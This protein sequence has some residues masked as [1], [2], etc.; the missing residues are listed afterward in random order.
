M[1]IA[2]A[3]ERN[4]IALLRIVFCWPGAAYVINARSDK[5]LP[6]R[7]AAWVRRHIVTAEK[8]ALCLLVAIFY[9]NQAKKRLAHDFENAASEFIAFNS[10]FTLGALTTKGIIKRLKSLRHILLNLRAIARRLA[11][12]LATRAWIETMKRAAQS[13][14]LSHIDTICPAPKLGNAIPP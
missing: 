8:A 12:I 6:L 14:V 7:L 2:G 13:H 3:I 11:N 9:S 10:A 1:S 4:R 5:P